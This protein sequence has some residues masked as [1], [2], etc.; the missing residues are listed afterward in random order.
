VASREGGN[1]HH[2][3]IYFFSKRL[4]FHAIGLKGN[5]PGL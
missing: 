2:G 4:K 3:L 1:P 5:W